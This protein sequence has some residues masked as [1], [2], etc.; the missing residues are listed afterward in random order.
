[1]DNSGTRRGPT[2]RAFVMRSSAGEVSLRAKKDFPLSAWYQW[3]V[4]ESDVWALMRV[5]PVMFQLHTR[6]AHG[7]ALHCRGNLGY[8]YI[9]LN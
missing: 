8:S 4:H 2:W 3:V 5:W 1:M 7:R 6:K 9:G